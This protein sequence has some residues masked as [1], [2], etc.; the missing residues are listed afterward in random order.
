MKKSKTTLLRFRKGDHAHNLIAAAQRWLRANGG[1]A[2]VMGGIGI[3]TMPGDAEARF[4]ITVGCLGRR[5][6]QMPENH[7]ER[8]P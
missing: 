7:T 2:L 5:P 4:S 1:D 3:L 6:K 8:K